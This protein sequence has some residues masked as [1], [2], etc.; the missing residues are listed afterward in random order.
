MSIQIQ[1][2]SIEELSASYQAAVAE[3]QAELMTKIAE[4]Q[5]SGDIGQVQELSMQVQAMIQ[6]LS[7]AF[8]AAMGALEGAPDP[9]ASPY[10]YNCTADLD[11]IV[12]DGDRDGLID[13]DRDPDVQVAYN[14]WQEDAAGNNTR[15]QLLKTSL[16]LTRKLAPTI[17]AIGDKCE[18]V[19]GMKTPI[20]F[21]V[22]QGDQFNASCWP[23]GD[24]RL[25]IM[26]SSGIVERFS[27]DELTFVIGHEI[28][29]VLFKHLKYH[30]RA[31]MDYG[32]GNLS[33]LHAMKLFA[34]GRAAEISAD[35][36]GLICCGDFT[37][38]GRAF[39]KLS[40]GVTSDSLSFDLDEYVQ[41]FIDLSAEM[42]GEAVDPQDWYSTHPF[43]P[44]RIKAL[45]LFNRSETYKTL[46]G[47]GD[48]SLTEDAM[49]QEIAQFMSLMEPAYLSKDND[50]G[51]DIQRYMFLSGYL[52]AMA[53]GLGRIIEPSVFQE[54]IAN[55]SELDENSM[56][57]EIASI[58]A[59]LN[60]VLSPM[61]KL[62]IL[63]DITLISAA[64]GEV[65][66]EEMNV[67]YHLCMFFN[68]HPEFADQV[69]HDS[70]QEVD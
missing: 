70:M 64:D 30:P 58:A 10:D 3:K 1:G 19:L 62:N 7:E 61:Q 49:E 47:N 37:A 35:R 36:V 45:E 8:Q 25:Y 66:Q 57:D 28:G 68:I 44:L 22:Y 32:G 5:A 29:H 31:I 14:A 21:Y 52:V 12:Y 9:N 40:S 16:K 59:K 17:Y 39:F 46:S 27:T 42:A 6:E 60:E 48:A 65:A 33:P 34:W 67:V 50:M 18:Q 2:S 23:P 43:S 26:L 13:F 11:L 38:A 20:E 53:D 69:I 54:C 51:A 56:K 41:Q 15:K 4:A 63:R 55:V 24:D